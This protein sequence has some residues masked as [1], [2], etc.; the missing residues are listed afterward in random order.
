V[1]PGLQPLVEVFYRSQLGRLY[2]VRLNLSASYVN[3]RVVNLR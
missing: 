3:I 1:G 2:S